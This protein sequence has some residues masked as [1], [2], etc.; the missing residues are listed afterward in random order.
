[1]ELLLALL[2][3]ITCINGYTLIKIAEILENKEEKTMSTNEK[4]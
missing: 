3:S 4:Q 2:L 1:M